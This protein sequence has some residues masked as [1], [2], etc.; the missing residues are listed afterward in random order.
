MS[1]NVD[2]LLLKCN[3]ARV[4]RSLAFVLVGIQ[5]MPGT[6]VSCWSIEEGAT[7]STD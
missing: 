6:F 3:V 1:E 5:S 2:H 4:L 7:Y